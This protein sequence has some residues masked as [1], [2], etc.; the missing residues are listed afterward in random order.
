MKLEVAE[1]SLLWIAREGMEV[2]I[3]IEIDEILYLK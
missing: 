1:A 2:A 3:C